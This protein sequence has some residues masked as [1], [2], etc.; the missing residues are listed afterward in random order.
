MVGAL[1]GSDIRSLITGVIA[2]LLAGLIT[3]LISIWCRKHKTKK[4]KYS[5]YWRTD[6]YDKNGNKTKSDYILLNY[7][8]KTDEF[9][10]KIKRYFPTEQNHRIW[11]CKGTFTGN[12]MLVVFWPEKNQ[13]ILSYGVEYLVMTGDYKYSGYYLKSDS[14]DVNGYPNIFPVKL[15]NS[16]LQNENDIF[17]A[18]KTFL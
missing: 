1:W 13:P 15:I 18:K 10:G 4:S 16:K 17:E 7:D 8:K 2:S 11:A 6:I 3:F 9:K 12:A 5:G 14:T